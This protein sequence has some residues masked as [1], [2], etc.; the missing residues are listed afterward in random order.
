[1]LHELAH[2]YFARWYGCQSGFRIWP[3]GLG[4]A[5]VMAILSRG[6]F[7]FAAPDAVYIVP[8][9]SFGITRRGNGVIAISGAIANLILA[10]VF[11]LV[12]TLGGLAEDAGYYGATVNLWLAAFNLIPLPQFDGAKVI[13]WNWKIWAALAIVA[14]LSLI[15]LA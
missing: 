3:A 4:L 7:I 8:R 15:L 13:S 1:V 2:R 9:S 5:L 14:W 6:R 10:L 12:S 11:V